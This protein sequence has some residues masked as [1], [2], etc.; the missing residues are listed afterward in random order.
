M[1]IEATK[2]TTPTMI[3]SYPNLDVPRQQTDSAGNPQGEPKFSGAFIAV[4][5]TDMSGVN[6]AIIAAAKKKWPNGVTKGKSKYTVEDAFAKGILASPIHSGTDSEDKGYPEGSSFFNARTKTKPG[7]VFGWAG[8]D[9]KVAKVPEDKI[10]DVFYA[11][12]LVRV[13]V[14]FYAYDVSGNMGVGVGL[15][16]VQFIGDG[17]RLDSRASAESEFEAVLSAPPVDISSVI[18]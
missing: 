18:G 10:R 1:S 17:P 13:S 6:A 12:S 14:N 5:G 11:G 4:A 2:I 8:P 9:G 15:N 3:L 16:H 7:A